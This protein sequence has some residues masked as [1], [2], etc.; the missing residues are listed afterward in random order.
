[1]M[2]REGSKKINILMVEDD[3]AD[4]RLTSEILSE[5]EC[6]HCHVSA[7]SD[8]V[9][10]L[11]FLHRLKGHKNAPRPDLILLDLNLPRMHGFE[12][13][14]RI[15]TDRKLKAI[16]VFILTTSAAEGDIEKAKALKAD[17]FFI[18]PLDLEE[19]EAAVS[20]IANIFP[21]GKCG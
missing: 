1:M 16:P 5:T 6:I 15:K 4:A 14:A 10:A 3:P 18:K 20:I 21:P 11:A 2:T 13:L 8:G 17:Y 19:F 12:L 7:V 9:D